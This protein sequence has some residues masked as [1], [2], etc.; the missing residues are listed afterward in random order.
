MHQCE[1]KVGVLV[2]AQKGKIIFTKRHDKQD[3]T[4]LS[5]NISPDQPSRTVERTI[6]RK[7]VQI[8]KPLVPD[9]CTKHI[10]GAVAQTSFARVTTTL[11][12]SRKK[13]INIYFGVCSPSCLQFLHSSV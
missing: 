7:T 12:G 11:E 3:V 13:G 10:E 1:D 4:L 6:R 2:Q 8:V 9:I 5:T